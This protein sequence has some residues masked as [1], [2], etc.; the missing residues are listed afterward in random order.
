MK[1]HSLGSVLSLS[2]LSLS[3]AQAAKYTVVEI[4]VTELGQ[5]SYAE[6]INDSGEVAVTVQNP[7][8]P[9]IDVSI[10]DFENEVLIA[11][12]TDLEGA[13]AGNINAEDL[14]ILYV[15]VKAGVNNALF[16]QLGTYQS[17]LVDDSS[18][19]SLPGLDKIQAELGVYSQSINT[20]THS[21][22]NIDTRIGTS[23]DPYYKINYTFEDGTDAIFQ[24]HDFTI[25]GWVDIN[26]QVFELPPIDTTLGGESEGYDVNNSLTA[27]GYGTVQVSTTLATAVEGCS[28][29]TTRGDLPLEVCLRGLMG[30][31]SIG[32]G[33]QRR[34]MVWQLDLTGNILESKQLGLLITPEEDD[35]RFYV[36]RALAIN[37]NGIIVGESQTYYQDDSTRLVSQAAIFNGD[38]VTGF[39]DDL[40]Y[41]NSRA[42]DINN[43]NLVV[44]QAFKTINGSSRSKFFVHDI[45]SG[46]TLYPLDF[47][48]GS[49]SEAHAINDNNLVV[50]EGEVE[51]TI[52]GVRARQAFL[53]DYNTE[54]FVNLNAMLS[55][56]SPYTLSQAKDINNNDEISATAVR[57]LPKR[58][59]AGNEALDSAGNVIFEDVVVAVKLVPVPGGNIDDCSASD[60]V[61]T[62]KGASLQTGFLFGLLLLTVIRVWRR[63]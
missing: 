1:I 46:E 25:R 9:P 41:F 30:S 53:Y 50:G 56:D 18:V 4:P 19:Q 61:F 37:D 32:S 47:F 15:Y 7:F 29:E 28:D 59:V 13:K 12:L 44:G 14:A 31:G 36:S 24:V 6:A 2:L 23:S 34:G 20:I 48:P 51:S 27:V 11:T 16:Q 55:C 38:D 62:R 5:Y 8:N 63:K 45:N 58:D 17:Y 21:L 10:V 49:S 22:N 42:E 52:T 57:R 3:V 40:D 39:V 54:E 33:F 60:E 35:S 26:G 43:S